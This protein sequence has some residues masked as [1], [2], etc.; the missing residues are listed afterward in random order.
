MTENRFQTNHDFY[1]HLG[2]YYTFAN[3][4]SNNFTDNIARDFQGI[5]ELSGM[6]KRLIMER[7]RF[8]NNWGH[9]MVRVETDSHSL[10]SGG[11]DMPSYIQFNYF[12][13]NR[14]IRSLEEYVDMYP[15]SY[16]IGLD[17]NILYHKASPT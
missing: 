16:T 14:F 4:S 10:R 17:F 11:L 13:F 12:Q 5:L 2:G 7:N 15:R 6:E 1:V 8:F 3:I 9:W